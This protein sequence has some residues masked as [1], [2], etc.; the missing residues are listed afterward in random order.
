MV[1]TYGAYP[2]VPSTNSSPHAVIIVPEKPAQL[3]LSGP[4]ISDIIQSNAR[5]LFLTATDSD[6]RLANMN[7]ILIKKS[8]DIQYLKTG[9]LFVECS[10]LSQ[11]TRLLEF[12]KL[13]INL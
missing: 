4:S 1:D 13:T 6:T 3:N 8:I 5:K 10:S 12:F 7:P 9:N 11:M 2:K